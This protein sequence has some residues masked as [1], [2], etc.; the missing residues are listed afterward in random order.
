MCQYISYSLSV[1]VLEFYNIQ[2]TLTLRLHL[3]RHFNRT[4][5][6]IHLCS[7]S[8][9][10]NFCF[11]LPSI[12]AHRL[13][14]PHLCHSLFLPCLS[15]SF[16]IQLSSS[17]LNYLPLLFSFSSLVSVVSLSPLPCLHFFTFPS[18]FHLMFLHLVNPIPPLSY[19]VHSFISRG[20]QVSAVHEAPDPAGWR[21]GGVR[22]WRAG[23]MEQGCA[24]PH[25]RRKDEADGQ[26]R[27][28]RHSRHQRHR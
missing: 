15:F 24:P 17:C 1:I 2:S 7:E 19:V 22:G 14:P 27:A 28:H 25:P 9:W 16:C 6:F 18:C 4:F 21:R 11:P 20:R 13:A 5:L 12:A 3:S 10:Q 23:V 8:V 26:V